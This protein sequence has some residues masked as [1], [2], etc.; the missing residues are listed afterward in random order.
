MQKRREK[1]ER[2]RRK[3]KDDEDSFGFS[4]GLSLSRDNKIFFVIFIIFVM[5]ILNFKRRMKEMKVYNYNSERIIYLSDQVKPGPP[6]VK[7]VISVTSRRRGRESPL[8]LKKRIVESPV[9]DS[10][11]D[12]LRQEREP[13]RGDN[14]R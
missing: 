6:S 11:A 1:N 12:A 3:D 10:F 5:R 8:P 4:W 2:E 7:R 9:G 14:N 13:R